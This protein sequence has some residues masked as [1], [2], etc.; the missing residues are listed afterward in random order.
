M[1]LIISAL[2][3]TERSAETYQDPSITQTLVEELA[4][5]W[6]TDTIEQLAK[7]FLA[8]P[9]T[10]NMETVSNYIQL[11]YT[12]QVIRPFKTAQALKLAL[13]DNKNRRGNS[14]SDKGCIIS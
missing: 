14:P 9:A 7:T 4:W 10:S 6:D 11:R 1:P 5:M 13:D 12:A 3:I 8:K 2:F